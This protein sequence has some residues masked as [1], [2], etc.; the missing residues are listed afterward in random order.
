MLT[1][2]QDVIKHN[3]HL[4]SRWF[5]LLI[6]LVS[7][8]MLTALLGFAVQLPVSGAPIG[9]E[10]RLTVSLYLLLISIPTA[11]ILVGFD[12]LVHIF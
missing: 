8:Q 5:M 4:R 10:S 11:L 7:L 12:V 3:F 2:I 9:L 6:I 1:V